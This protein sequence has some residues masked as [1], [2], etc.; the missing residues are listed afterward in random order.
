MNKNDEKR[1]RRESSKD[2]RWIRSIKMKLNVL[3]R[4]ERSK[5]DGAQN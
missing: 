5:T 3:T 1:G 4:V 2:L